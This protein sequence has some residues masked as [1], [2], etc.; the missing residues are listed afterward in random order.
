MIDPSSRGCNIV[1]TQWQQIGHFSAVCHNYHDN[2][3]TDKNI[4]VVTMA[5]IHLP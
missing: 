2:N 1:T 4:S 3:K 5:T